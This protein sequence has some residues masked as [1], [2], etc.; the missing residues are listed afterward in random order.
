[1]FEKVLVSPMNRT[2]VFL[3][4]TAAEMFRIAVQIAII[5]GL[6]VVLGADVTT[7]L[8]GAV[9]IIAVGMLFSLWFLALSNSLAVVTRDQESTIIA[10]N[11]LQFP[12]LFLSTAFLPLDSLPGWVQTFATYNPVTYGVDAAR[13][14]MLDQ[15]VMTVLDVSAFGGTL[16]GVIPGVAVLLALDLVLGA[17][18][19]F[20]ISRASSSRAR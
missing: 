15:D 1:M 5:L 10:A 12:L 6:G 16:D 18:A 7:G 4:K 9:G 17:V 20:L 19:V 14:L 13:S 11:L 2:A 8:A 3:G